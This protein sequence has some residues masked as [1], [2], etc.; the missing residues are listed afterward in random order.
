MDENEIICDALRCWGARHQAVVAIEE[1]SELQKE[2]CKILRR[3][4][5]KEHAAEEIADV[6]IMLAQMK[7]ALGVEHAVKRYKY[8]K[9]ARL[10]KRIAERRAAK[11]G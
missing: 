9:L 4:G 10:E 1:L 7:K 6:E 3:Q 2:L 8:F 5:N 11:G